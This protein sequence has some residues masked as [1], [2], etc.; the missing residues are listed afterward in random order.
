LRLFFFATSAIFF[1]SAEVFANGFSTKTSLP[2]FKHS[3]A[4]SVCVP[5]GVAI[6]TAS[7][8]HFSRR[9]L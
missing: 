3:I 6:T 1:A 5:V 4:I 8:S 9:S 2:A 7:T